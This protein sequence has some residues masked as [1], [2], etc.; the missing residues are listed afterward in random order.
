MFDNILIHTFWSLMTLTELV[1]SKLYNIHITGLISYITT[2][3][4]LMPLSEKLL[5]FSAFLAGILQ[6]IINNKKR[7]SLY[8]HWF[9]VMIQHAELYTWRAMSIATFLSHISLSVIISALESNI[10]SLFQC[11]ILNSLNSKKKTHKRKTWTAIARIYSNSC[12][13]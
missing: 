4:L 8:R 11:I 7:S 5:L 2:I 10:S 13:Q 6:D 12:L 9:L 3:L 1:F